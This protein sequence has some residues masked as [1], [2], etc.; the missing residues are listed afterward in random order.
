M[1]KAI[2]CLY[3][4]MATKHVYQGRVIMR[5]VLVVEHHAIIT[6]RSDVD[7]VSFDPVH[8]ISDVLEAALG[9]AR[10]QGWSRIEG[11]SQG[12]RAGFTQLSLLHSARPA[13]PFTTA[14]LPKNRTLRSGCCHQWVVSSV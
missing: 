13:A 6:V 14:L 8:N 2:R 12:A 11:K 1:G 4:R 3:P 9:G 10:V 7:D 5:V